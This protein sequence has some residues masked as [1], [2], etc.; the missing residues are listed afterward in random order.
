ML[1]GIFLSLLGNILIN[2]G[3]HLISKSKMYWGYGLFCLGN[4]FSFVSFSFAPQIIVASL[5]S[6]QFLT[7][8]VFYYLFQNQTIILD[9]II[10]T[11]CVLFGNTLI[12]ITTSQF[13]FDFHLSNSEGFDNA[14]SFD[15][16]TYC[17]SIGCICIC[18]Q[19]YFEKYMFPTLKDK[20][21]LE[22]QTRF[23]RLYYAFNIEH[24]DKALNR[25]EESAIPILLVIQSTS[26]GSFT[27]LFSNIISRIFR[28]TIGEEQ[29]LTGWFVYLI[30]TFL[31]IFVLFWTRRMNRIIK[32][33]GNKNIIPLLQI[34]WIFFSI[35]AG[36]L[37]FNEF[38]NYDK[39]DT[40][41]FCSSVF[42]NFIGVKLLKN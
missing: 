14:L 12:I 32:V 40:M 29:Q 5:S 27:T 42:I 9:N 11:V 10:G 13:S 36:G 23:E 3:T 33:F 20:Y 2:S 18:L 34:F 19:V 24:H 22:N 38:D 6:V 15:F 41:V 35:L 21:D 25:L 8:L 16:V 39:K 7:N 4:V 17:I 26:I 28:T 30:I 37:Y 31:V 1:F